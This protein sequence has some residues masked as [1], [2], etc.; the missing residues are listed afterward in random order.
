MDSKIIP[1][2]PYAAK[3]GNRRKEDHLSHWRSKNQPNSLKHSSDLRE[4]EA[5][6]AGLESFL[7][8]SQLWK[9]SKTVIT[10]R[11]H[12]RK[13]NR[14]NNTKRVLAFKPKNESSQLND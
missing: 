13:T 11:K 5:Y 12:N 3:L 8:R 14:L 2:N 1:M 10:N 4:I 9:T 6:L 7:G